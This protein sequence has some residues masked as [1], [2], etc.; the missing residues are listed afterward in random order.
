MDY[1][2]EPPEVN[3]GRI[4]AGVGPGPL[5][6]AAAAWQALSDEL[7]AAAMGHSATTGELLTGPWMGPSAVM[8]G[9]SG[10]QSVAWLIQASAQCMEASGACA[11]AAAA[12]SEAFI[13][14]TPPPAIVANRTTLATLVATN[15]LGVNSPAI[16]ALEAQYS[17]MWAQTSGALY[18]YTGQSAATAG[19]LMPLT[20]M[21]PNTNPAGLAAQGASTAAA[22]GQSAGTSGQTMSSMMSS[23]GSLPQAATSMLQGGP[24]MLGQIPKMLS[25]LAKPLSSMLQPMTQAGQSFMGSGVLNGLAS[26]VS[27]GVASL[28]GFAPSASSGVFSGGGFS[29]VAATM[30][31]SV[32]LGSSQL[33]VPA[34]WV[35]ATQ[36]EK[37]VARPIEMT[38]QQDDNNSYVGAAPRAGTGMM[39]GMMGQGGM[40]GAAPHDWGTIAKREGLRT[41]LIGDMTGI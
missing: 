9:V 17:E 16:A 37:A 32:P 34:Q 22:T 27:G 10:A 21:V 12:F 24:Q 2:L 41:K 20:P 31:K 33:S 35:S 14:V 36:T 4:Y 6:A 29:G 8:M 11:A 38:Q 15:F 7:A 18:N 3:S 5:L 13:G 1:G 19:A 40:A 26:G 28:A 39:P 23:L 25:E 30:G